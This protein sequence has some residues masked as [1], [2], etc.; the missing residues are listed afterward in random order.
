MRE[1]ND[2]IVDANMMRESNDVSPDNDS[3]EINNISSDIKGDN[4]KCNTMWRDYNI[5]ISDNK[6]SRLSSYEYMNIWV[7]N[8]I[9]A[10][11]IIY[12]CWYRDYLIVLL[13]YILC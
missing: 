2:D 9:N 8:I 11:I 10:E 4:E 13:K 5:S 6:S 12:A 3:D 7:M 1:S